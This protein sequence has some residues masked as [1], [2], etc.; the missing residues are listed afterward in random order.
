MFGI[1]VGL[2]TM[3]AAP[4]A[5]SAQETCTTDGGIA[6]TDYFSLSATIPSDGAAGVPI[7][8]FIRLRYGGPAPLRAFV[9]VQD[10]VRHVPVMG[11]VNVVGD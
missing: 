10:L 3:C 2:A 6:P 1:L 4:S 9:I 8:G 5:A 7:D 11:T